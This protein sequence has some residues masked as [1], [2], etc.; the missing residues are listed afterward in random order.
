[1]NGEV[2]F[3]HADKHQSALQ[4]YTIIVGVPFQASPKYPKQELWI[5]FQ[6]LQKNIWDEVDFL[7]VDKC[8]SFLQVDSITL[9]VRSQACSKYPK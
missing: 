4:V 3:W 2:Y 9:G 5:S 8:K 7:L 6:Y 1:M